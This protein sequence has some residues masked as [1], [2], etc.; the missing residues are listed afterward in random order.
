MRDD[1]EFKIFYAEVSHEIKK[2]ADGRGGYSVDF[3]KSLLTFQ[4]KF[5]N[6]LIVYGLTTVIYFAIKF[7]N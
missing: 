5:R 1:K 4:E 3:F 6:T 7:F 2:I